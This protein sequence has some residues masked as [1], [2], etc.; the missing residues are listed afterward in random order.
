MP[1]GR[2]FAFRNK[3]TGEIITFSKYLT[4]GNI[5]CAE[6]DD[7]FIYIGGSF[8]RVLP[9]FTGHLPRFNSSTCALNK[10]SSMTEGFNSDLRSYALDGTSLYVTGGFTSYNSVGVSCIAKLN[11]ETGALDSVFDTIGAFSPA[12]SP[13]YLRPFIIDGDYIY[14]V[15]PFTSYKGVSRNYIAKISKINAGLDLSFDPGIGFDS[16]TSLNCMVQDE[17]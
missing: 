11:V 13:G 1:Y 7:S 15:G 3:K 5:V 10:L 6:D 4:N 2:P 16:G 9:E 8:T 17:Q 14:M 12:P